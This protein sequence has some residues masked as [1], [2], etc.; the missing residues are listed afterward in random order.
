MVLILEK[1]M[2]KKPAILLKFAPFTDV[3]QRLNLHNMSTF[4][5][6]S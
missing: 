6:R 2:R 5:L 3:L 4:F 1:V